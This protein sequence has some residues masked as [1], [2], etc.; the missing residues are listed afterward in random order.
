MKHFYALLCLICKYC[1]NIAF[2]LRSSFW[3][4]SFWFSVRIDLLLN[5]FSLVI[6]FPNWIPDSDYY[7]L[8]LLDSFLASDCSVCPAVAFPP[9]E[10]SDRLVS[11]FYWLSFK[12]KGGCSF[13]SQSI[14]QFV[15]WFGYSL[16]S[17]KRCSMW[18]YLYQF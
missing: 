11:V 7:S 5:N 3:I 6:N 9:L 13:S 12:L 17:F 8:A 1:L 18:W 15:C 2:L 10:N 16:W 4:L 14:W